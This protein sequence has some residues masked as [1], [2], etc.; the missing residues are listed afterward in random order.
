MDD[1]GNLNNEIAQVVND[2]NHAAEN[3]EFQ[4]SR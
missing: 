1:R 2:S 3:C 4:G